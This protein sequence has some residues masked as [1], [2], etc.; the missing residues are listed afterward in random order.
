MNVFRNLSA[1]AL[2][3]AVGLGVSFSTQADAAEVKWKIA[4]A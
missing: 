2:A 4:T 3:A 1:L